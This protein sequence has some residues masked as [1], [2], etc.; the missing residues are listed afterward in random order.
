MSQHS[1]L[2]VS[3]KLK[4]H[5]SVLKRFERIRIL[6]KQGSWNESADSVYGLPKVKSIKIRVKKEKAPET[7]ETATAEAKAPSAAQAGA[8]G[9]SAKPQAAGAKKSAEAKR[10]AEQAK[11]KEEKGSPAKKAGSAG[12][13]H[14]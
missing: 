2:K 11:G 4:K 10:P 8:Q 6:L 5:R 12:A 7:A 3:S 13:P 9:V 14:K 1:S